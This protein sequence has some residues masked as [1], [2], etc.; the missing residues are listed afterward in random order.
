MRLALALALMLACRPAA[1]ACSTCEAL[2]VELQKWH[3][4]RVAAL[5]ADQGWLTLAGLY[6]LDEGEHELG[7]AETSDLV[8][9]AGAPP[10]I[11]T[12]TLLNGEVRLRTAD[13]VDARIAGARVGDV[14]LRSDAD[15]ALPADRVELG[16]RF[17]FLIIKRG[18][19]LAVRLYDRESPARRGFAG[20][21]RFPASSAWQIKARFE[22]H[23]KPRQVE[24]PTVLGASVPAEV[25]GVAVF[26][27]DG[28]EHRLAP[29]LERGPHGDELLFVFRDLTSGVET[30]AGGRFL[31]TPLPTDGALV[32]DF[33]RAHNPPCAFTEHATC[34]VPLPENRLALRVEAGEHT[35]A[36]H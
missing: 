34:P 33:N 22:A 9:P 17:T 10:T 30:Y 2:A 18:E 26:T 11:G 32:L 25:P 6:W 36:G 20:I 14:A 7:A 5:R 35:P 24:H 1:P 19:R 29:I 21:P 8:F 31:V 13:G 15:P 28:A 16:A 4:A 12:L 27:V 23:E 3:D